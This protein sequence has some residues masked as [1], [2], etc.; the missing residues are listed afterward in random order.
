M[1][2][3]PTSRSSRR[4]R[5]RTSRTPRRPRR[6]REP[7]AEPPPTAEAPPPR[8]RASAGEQAEEVVPGADLEPDLVLDDRPQED[9][10]YADAAERYPTAAEDDEAPPASDEAPAPAEEPQAATPMTLAADARY[11]A[12]GKRKTSVARVILS[13]GDGSYTVNG[14][15]LEEF[16][17]RPTLQKAARQPLAHGGLRRPDECRR[18]A[19]R[20]RRL[21]PGRSAQARH[22]ARAGRRGPKPSRRPEAARVPHARPTRQG[23]QE[24]RPQE[25]AQAPAVL[26]ALSAP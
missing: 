20:R 15:P 12:T 16:F 10:R 21:V 9:D 17:P 8:D 22:R 24:G 18:E 6:P 26:E 3:R 23:A 2:H 1:S 7:E 4:R 14:R 13:P 11:T 19:P 5:R 25:G